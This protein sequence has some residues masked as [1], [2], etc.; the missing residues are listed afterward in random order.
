MTL[1]RYTHCVLTA[2]LAVSAIR[3]TPPPECGDG[4]VND[5]E[6][7]TTCCEDTGCASGTCGDAHAC[8]TAWNDICVAPGCAPTQ[9]LLC[10]DDVRAPPAY[11]CAQ[12][13]C[14][15]G[16]ACIDAVCVSADVRE[17]ERNDDVVSD[18]LDDEDYVALLRL[19]TRGRAR[20]VTDMNPILVQR[21]QLD[22]RIVH[23]LMGDDAVDGHIGAEGLLDGRDVSANGESRD[24]ICAALRAESG[25][26]PLTRLQA[27]LPVDQVDDVTC[28]HP[29]VFARCQPPA[30]AGCAFAAG[31]SAERFLVVGQ[32]AYQTVDDALLRHAVRSARVQWIT[33]IDDVVARYNDATAIVPTAAF[34]DPNTNREVRVVADAQEGVW[35]VLIVPVDSAPHRL[36]SFRALLAQ[37]TSRTFLEN[38]DMLPTDCTFRVSAGI[39][40]VCERAGARLQA[41]LTLDHIILDVTTEGG[42]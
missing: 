3:C 4:V 10:I 42:T 18:L 38:N 29:G 21:R 25:L 14:A 39:D 26:A 40:V 32:Q 20:S 23:R 34:V 22:A 19:L 30:V 31:R 28:L 11:D 24:D 16:G 15:D 1:H 27:S 9:P 33:R 12:C 36:L 13:G 17:Q 8:V 41:T 37:A 35:W 7:E 6:D 2:L 5:G